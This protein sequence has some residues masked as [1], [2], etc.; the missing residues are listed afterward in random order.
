V[1]IKRLEDY[2]QSFFNVEKKSLL[3]NYPGLTLHRLRSDIKLHA[4]LNGVDSEELFEFPYI[5]HRTNPITFFFEKLKEGVPLEYITGYAYFYRSLFKV[6]PDVLIPRSETEILVELASQEIQKNYRNK[7]CRLVDVGTGSGVI[8]LTLMMEDFAI[9]DVVA[10]DISDKAL[11]LAK[12]NFFNLRYAISAKHNIRFFKSDRLQELEGN[13]D[14]ILSNPPYIKRLGDLAS[15]HHQVLSYEPAMALFLDDDL[16]DKWFEDFFRSIFQ[17]LL[18][19]GIS[20]IEGHEDHLLGLSET[21]SKLGFAK[22]EII[23]DYTG[24]NRFLRL[25]K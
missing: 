21:V 23:K 8:A 4:F 15:I 18:P 13:F 10:T 3:S 1:T 16:Y 14:I 5:P 2:L 20:L 12:E 6:T 19:N 7:I 24:R 25:K 22:V 17:K 9:L 11:T